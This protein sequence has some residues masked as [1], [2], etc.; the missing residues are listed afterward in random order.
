MA[1]KK[2]GWCYAPSQFF[3]CFCRAPPCN[4]AFANLMKFWGQH[5]YLLQLLQNLIDIRHRGFCITQRQR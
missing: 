1:A 3:V 4:P 5:I 2:L